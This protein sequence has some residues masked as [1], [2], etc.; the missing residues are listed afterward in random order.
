MVVV[1]AEDEWELRSGAG[2]GEWAEVS[3]EAKA[4]GGRQMA[5][6]ANGGYC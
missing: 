1:A 3:E 2:D 4:K 5:G 6:R